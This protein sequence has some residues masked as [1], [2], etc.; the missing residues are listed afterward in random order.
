LNSNQASDRTG[1]PYARVRSGAVAALLSAIFPGLGQAYLGDRRKAIIFA[2]PVIALIVLVGL[3][4][5][6]NRSA[7]IR[8]LDPSISFA[9]VFVVVLFGL[10]W[11]AAIANAWM[12]GPH[13]GTAPVAVLLVLLLLVG[14][15]DAYG[16][17]YFLRIHNGSEQIFTGNPFDQTPPPPTPSPTP[18]P[19]GQTPDPSATPTPRPPDYNDPSDD[20][21]GQPTPDIEPGETPDF[22]ITKIDATDDGLL[23]VL[24][25]GVDWQPGRT[26]KRTDTILVVSA[27]A[28]TGEVLM[29]SFPRDSARFPLYNG[30]IY[31]GKINT[32][33]GFANA[34]PQLYP[35]GGIKA[36]AYEAGYLLGIPIDYYASVNM[37]GF[38]S[39]VEQVGGITVNNTRD[40]HD[41]NLQ[42][43]LAPGTYRLDA[44]DALRYVRSRHGSGGDFGRAERQQQVLSALRKEILKPENLANLP[45]IVEAMSQVINT[46]FPPDQI[47]Q[48]VALADQVQSEVSQSWIFG[49]P[50]WATHLRAR[51][52]CGR[53]VQFLRLD[54]IAALSIELFG[55]KSLW[56]G[57]TPP[58]PAGPKECATGSEPTPTP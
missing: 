12:S 9:L 27:N 56:N 57:K 50:E 4:L 14:A 32:F 28:A 2:A 6:F 33:A 15:A 5:L 21:S 34:N 25:V 52:T 53:S 26:S 30:G 18:L 1:T 19:V 46:D 17:V 44:A 36:L 22:D 23:N 24:L 41:D 43:Y 7:A 35:G 48:L 42:F 11:V 47:D 29:F 37:P 40:I 13:L 58:P 31:N 45:A 39:V 20:P 55:D 10:W 54:K 3:V 51:E 49:Y 38:M 8:V 16:A